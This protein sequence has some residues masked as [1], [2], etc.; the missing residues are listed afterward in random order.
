MIVT[1][2]RSVLKY[3]SFSRLFV[4]S[5]ERQINNTEQDFIV[6]LSVVLVKETNKLISCCGNTGEKNWKTETKMFIMKAL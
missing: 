6:M 4:L 5:L 2:F 3:F 1:D